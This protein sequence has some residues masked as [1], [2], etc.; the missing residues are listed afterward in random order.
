M[1]NN[2]FHI[3][4]KQVMVYHIS[5]SQIKIAKIMVL[6]VNYMKSSK[7]NTN[8]YKKSKMSKS[9][10]STSECMA[11]NTKQKTEK[12]PFMSKSKLNH[13]CACTSCNIPTEH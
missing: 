10:C 9:I 3:V 5:H 4:K 13:K 2:C 11:K 7:A 8:T 1:M 6:T 12:V